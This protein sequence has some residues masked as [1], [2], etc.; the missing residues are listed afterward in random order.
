MKADEYDPP[1]LELDYTLCKIHSMGLLL[2]QAALDECVEP[3]LFCLA[4]LGRVITDQADHGL[5]ILFEVQAE[6]RAKKSEATTNHA[7]NSKLQPT[8]PVRYP[9][10]EN[11]NSRSLSVSYLFY[12][13]F[14]FLVAISTIL[15]CH[16]RR[17]ERGR[18]LCRNIG[19]FLA[20][21]GPWHS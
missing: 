9:S 6:I 14:G 2:T 13:V 17:S 11:S 7:K 19:S 21:C 12:L 20:T 8:E 4:D 15:P 18:L 1:T 3:D 10:H 5:E 16:A